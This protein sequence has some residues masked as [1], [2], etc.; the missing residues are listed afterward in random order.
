MSIQTMNNAIAD[1]F[2]TQPVVTAGLFGL[3]SRGEKNGR[4]PRRSLPSSER[5]S[6][7]FLAFQQGRPHC[8]LFPLQRAF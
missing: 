6:T 5:A 1:Y 3:Y 7:F 4:A 8:F 2:K